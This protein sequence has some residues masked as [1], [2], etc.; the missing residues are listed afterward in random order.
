MKALS[1]DK[2]LMTAVLQRSEEPAGGA[3]HGQQP[4][5]LLFIQPRTKSRRTTLCA[6]LFLGGAGSWGAGLRE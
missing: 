5:S 1:T 3:L 2:T 6:V 4:D